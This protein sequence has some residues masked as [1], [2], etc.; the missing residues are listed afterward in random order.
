MN[1]QGSSAVPNDMTMVSMEATSQAKA[2]S[3]DHKPSDERE[4]NR[5]N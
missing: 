2:L 5:I 4:F 3:R 1:N